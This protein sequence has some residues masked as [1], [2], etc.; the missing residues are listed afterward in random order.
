LA[1]THHDDD[2]LGTMLDAL[3]EADPDDAGLLAMLAAGTVLVLLARPPG[4]GVNRPERNLVEWKNTT[5]DNVFVPLFTA[6][7]R[8]PG[9]F[10]APMTLTRVPTRLLLSLAG[11]RYYV[12]NPLSSVRLI[13][14]PSRVKRIL[15]HV[16]AQSGET[17]VP[18]PHVPWGF[19]L[20]PDE[21]YP[22]AH[23]LAAWI[24][25]DGRLSKAFLYELLRGE[26]PPQMVLGLEVRTDPTLAATLRAVAEQAGAPPGALTVRFLPDEPSHAQGVSGMGLEPFYQRPT[27]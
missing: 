16:A 18:S 22:I 13:L 19:R 4:E 12:L 6:A 21:W 27:Q 11:S 23:A 10:P 9:A 15:E 14:T 17:S 5:E 8:M 3:S 25:D 1:A 26:A 20:P 24:V 2:P 7:R